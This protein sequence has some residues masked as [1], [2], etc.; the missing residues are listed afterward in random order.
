ER[1]LAFFNPATVTD[2][3][4][5]QIIRAKTAIGSGGLLGKGLFGGPQNLKGMVPIKES[6]FIFTVSGEELGFI[7]SSIII[8]LF[9]LLLIRCIYVAQ[10]A[11]DNYGTL[12]IAGIT[13]MLGFHFIENIGM[14]LG[15]LPIT[16]IPLPYFSLG[17]SSMLTV[18]IAVGI[19]L[20][21]S[22]RKRDPF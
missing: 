22:M 5:Y 4:A 6:D 14:N 12:L 18:F 9:V 1:I 10:R 16:G 3:S 15:L 7:G 13:G 17:N 19:I 2:D 20:S 11:R 8:V 21:V